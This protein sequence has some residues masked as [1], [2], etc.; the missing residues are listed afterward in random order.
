MSFISF[1]KSNLKIFFFLVTCFNI[2]IALFGIYTK[3]S[4]YFGYESFL[5]PIILGAI[6][7]FPSYIL[8]AKNESSIKTIIGNRILHFLLIEII[9]LAYGFLKGIYV[10]ISVGIMY[11]YFTIIIYTVVNIL[12]WLIDFKTADIINKGLK[13]LR[14]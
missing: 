12:S 3:P 4:P 13:K 7:V 9:L 11:L 14:D 6:V 10:S 2:I 8:H 5:T 1:V